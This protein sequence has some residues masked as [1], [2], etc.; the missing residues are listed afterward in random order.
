[1][2]PQTP[3]NLP[4]ILSSL[5]PGFP[6][7]VEIGCGN[8][9]FLAEYGDKNRRLFLLGVEMKKKRCLKAAAKLERRRLDSAFI[10][11]GRAEDLLAALPP[12]RVRGFHVYFPDPWPK[13]KHRKRRFLRLETLDRLYACLENGGTIVFASDFFDY[14]LQVKI[15]F[16]VHPGFVLADTGAPREFYL[17]IYAQKSRDLGRRIYSVVARKTGLPASANQ[18]MEQHQHQQEV[19]GQA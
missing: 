11:Q 3:E 14:Y 12:G 2:Q 5:P 7:E 4:R 6:L 18:V 15:L 8:G 9:H 13:T 17:S 16:L 19:D 1:M 10:V